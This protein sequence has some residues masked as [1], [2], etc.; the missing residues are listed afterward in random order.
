[1]FESSFLRSISTVARLIIVLLF[2]HSTF[3]E[4]YEHRL[5]SVKWFESPV[6]T[7][8]ARKQGMPLRRNI[9]FY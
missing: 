8:A 9:L 3:S 7:T 5:K 1:M 2:V 4:R 6:L